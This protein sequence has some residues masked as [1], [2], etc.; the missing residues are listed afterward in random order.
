MENANANAST[1]AADLVRKSVDAL[2]TF[3]A[4]NA[5]ESEAR[6]V[7]LGLDNLVAIVA[8][9]SRTCFLFDALDWFEDGGPDSEDYGDDPVDDLDRWANKQDVFSDVWKKLEGPAYAA[10]IPVDEN[11]IDWGGEVRTVAGI[12]LYSDGDGYREVVAEPLGHAMVPASEYD[13][14]EAVKAASDLEGF[15]GV[16]GLPGES[17]FN[18]AW[19]ETREEAAAWL[20]GRDTGLNYARILTAE[21]AFDEEW[22]DGSKVFFQYQESSSNTFEPIGRTRTGKPA[23]GL[24][25]GVVCLV[26]FGFSWEEISCPKTKNPLSEGDGS[27]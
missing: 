1:S 26:D 14:D 9:G 3:L 22:R 2:K 12:N 10:F 27:P 16:V 15:F 18:F 7:D 24:S 13:R 20:D 5:P 8:D 23:P 21:G 25:P 6:I 17:G 19:T 4:E 11:G